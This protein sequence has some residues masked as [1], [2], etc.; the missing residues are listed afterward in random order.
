MALTVQDPQDYAVMSGFLAPAT[1]NGLPYLAPNDVLALSAPTLTAAKVGAVL[2]LAPP[3]FNGLPY[4]ASPIVL[5]M[6]SSY[7]AGRGRRSGRINIR[8]APAQTPHYDTATRYDWR[9]NEQAKMLAA[10]LDDEE[11][12]IAFLMELATHED[13]KSVV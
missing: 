6:P 9:S 7:G 4:L 8:S 13:R 10:Q 3:L 11:V 1:V 5:V 12:V 2:F